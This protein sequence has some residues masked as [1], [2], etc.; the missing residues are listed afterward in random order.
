MSG[1]VRCMGSGLVSMLSGMASGMASAG[2]GSGRMVLKV[3]NGT[4]T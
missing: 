4:T 1:I 2:K 3:V